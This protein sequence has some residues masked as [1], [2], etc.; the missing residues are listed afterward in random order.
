MAKPGR[1]PSPTPKQSIFCCLDS[2]GHQ[3]VTGTSPG[4]AVVWQPHTV[5][6][7]VTSRPGNQGFFQSLDLHPRPRHSTP[8]RQREG[9]ARGRGQAVTARHR[10]GSATLG[11]ATLQTVAHLRARQEPQHRWPASARSREGT[12]ETDS[13]VQIPTIVPSGCRTFHKSLNLSGLTFPHPQ[14]GG[15]TVFIRDHRPPEQIP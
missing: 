8:G 2:G 11:E 4:Q 12:L 5:N 7:Q 6:R 3:A 14:T 15:G 13:W 10:P 9:R 1:P